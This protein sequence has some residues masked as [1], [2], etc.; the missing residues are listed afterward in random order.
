MVRLSVNLCIDAQILSL[1]VMRAALLSCYG[2]GR[3][4]ESRGPTG[5]SNQRYGPPGNRTAARRNEL[6]HAGDATRS[7]IATAGRPSLLAKPN[8]RPARSPGP[9]T[10]PRRPG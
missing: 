6:G 1:S 3:R 10:L 4:V 8:A 2:P 7:R 5:G 9:T